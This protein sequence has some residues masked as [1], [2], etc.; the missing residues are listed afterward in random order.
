MGVTE[1]EDIGRRGNFLAGDDFG[2]SEEIDYEV[3]RMDEKVEQG[4]TLWIVACEVMEVV[5]DKMLF[6]Q[7]LTKDLHGRGIA[8]L[9]ADHGDR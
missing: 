5:I 3:E 6:A 7:S 1:H 8:F 2:V 4:I 9:Q